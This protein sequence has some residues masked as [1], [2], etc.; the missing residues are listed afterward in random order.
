P[1]CLGKTKPPLQQKEVVLRKCNNV[2]CVRPDHLYLETRKEVS[3]K[4][5]MF[6]ENN[7][8]FGKKH[9]PNTLHKMSVSRIGKTGIRATAWKGGLSPLMTRLRGLLHH[10]LGW[11]AAVFRRDR[12]TC[13]NCG[14][15]NK[16]IDAHHIRPFWYEN[17][18]QNIR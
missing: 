11:Y 5:G 8:M 3:Q 13:T 12:W 16:K 1:L 9:S 4:A 17:Y 14:D 18:L 7:P 15:K 6:G 2:F 10:R